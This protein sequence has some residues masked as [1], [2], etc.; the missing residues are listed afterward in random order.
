[1]EA[2]QQGTRFRDLKDDRLESLSH[3]DNFSIAMPA[4]F[5]LEVENLQPHAPA[6]L[7]LRM[8]KTEFRE[9]IRV[10]V[11]RLHEEMAVYALP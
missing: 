6:N 5:G 1:V 9:V 3:Q 11:A 2:R 8:K 7:I 10:Q 4:G